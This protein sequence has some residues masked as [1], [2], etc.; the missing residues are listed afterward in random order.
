[1]LR[2]PQLAEIFEGKIF[3]LA[4][5]LITDTNEITDFTQGC[6]TAVEIIYQR[7]QCISDLTELIYACC[8]YAKHNILLKHRSVIEI[9]NRTLMAFLRKPN[10]EEEFIKGCYLTQL[11]LQSFKEYF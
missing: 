2:N 1:M 7:T 6:V 11:F 5:I 4:G 10:N 3:L 9:F 8:V